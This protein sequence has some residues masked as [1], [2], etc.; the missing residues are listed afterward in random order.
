[1][2][3]RRKTIFLLL[4]YS[5]M[6][7]G[8]GQD[9]DEEAEVEL[10]GE[11]YNIENTTFINL[12]YQEGSDYPP[13]FGEIPSEI[14][15]LVN[16]TDLYLG[17]NELTVIPPEIGNL[18]NLQS[19]FLYGNDFISIPSEIGNLVNLKTLDIG[20]N[21]ITGIPVELYSLNSLEL[22]RLENNQL[23]IEIPPEIENLTNLTNL[24]LS[25]NELV[26]EIPVEVG[27]LTNLSELNL[28]SNQLIGEIPPEIGNLSNL[29]V[30]DL[31]YNQFMGE[32]PPEI[33]NLNYVFLTNNQ[34][35]PPYPECVDDYLG[36]QDTS[37]CF[38]PGNECQV[39]DEYG[40]YDCYE[41]CVLST[42]FEEWLGD[43]FCDDSNVSFN[44]TEL[45]YDC[46]DCSEDW[47]G[48]NS[49]GFCSEC[50]LGDINNDSLFDVLD[51]VSMITLI[52][53]VEYDE[54]GDI[55]S[56]RYLNVLDVVT[57]VNFILDN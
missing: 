22:L 30:L 8:W 37:E 19:L 52:L 44:C 28:S 39:G 2:G 43:G 45:G 1:M 15:Q 25:Y 48:T 54:C 35:C 26:G 13:L 34:L 29:Y 57:L 33:C 42:Y 7:V 51:I 21:Q 23:T 41:F 27:N 49:L 36:Y 11:C 55:N 5:F 14:G 56:D 3:L 9:C 16:I 4:F 18:V 31:S 32:I 40:Y 53:E 50:I 46:G 47:D 24:I 17:G 10:W 20:F 38:N 6:S 12:S